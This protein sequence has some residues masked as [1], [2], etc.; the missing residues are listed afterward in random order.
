MTFTLDHMA[1]GGIRDH[2]GGGYHRY[3]T[4]RFWL[5]PHFEKMLYDN[6]Q[7]AS[8]HLAAFEIT[9]DAAL[10]R[11]GRSH[12]SFRRGKTDFARGRLL[13]RTRRRDQWRRGGVLRLDPRRGQGCAGRRAEALAFSQVY[14]LTGE[15]N[16]EEGRYVLHEPRPRAEQAAALEHQPGT[17][18]SAAGARCASGCWRCAR[19][20][21]R[22]CAMTRSLTAW[23]G[24]MIAAYAD[25]YRVLKDATIP[26]SRPRRPQT[27]C[28]RS[29]EPRMD[30]CCGPIGLGS[31]KFP[32]YL[33]D[34]AF[35]AFGLLRLHRATGDGRWLRE[36]Q[37]LVDRMIADFE[38][39]EEGG[40]FFTATDHEQL[41]GAG[42]RPV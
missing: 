31:A 27:S 9:N 15:P 19:S 28:S 41:S 13:L 29:C 24:L 17:A 37:S 16:A 42:Q 32:A 7:L 1:R 12:V 2:L 30:G 21:R 20:G 26:S 36:A 4:D 23:N 18:R 22:P 33:E 6:A 25:G 8:V 11:R 3:S 34:Y 38:D 40:F 35:L 5:V 39:K 10:A 14:G